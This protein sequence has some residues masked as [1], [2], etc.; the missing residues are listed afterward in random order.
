MSSRIQFHEPVDRWSDFYDQAAQIP[1]G[2]VNSSGWKNFPCVLPTHPK[3]DRGRHGGINVFSGSYR[4]WNEDCQRTAARRL[5][6]DPNSLILTP[7]EFLILTRDLSALDAHAAVEAYRQSRLDDGPQFD[8]FDEA[9]SRSFIPQSSEVLELV[10]GAQG[11][12]H[13]NLDIVREYLSARLLDYA[14]L[15]AAG[16]GY[17]PESPGQEECLIFPYTVDGRIVGIRGRTLDSRKGGIRNSWACLYNLDTI[18]PTDRIGII[19]EGETDTLFLQQELRKAGLHFPVLGTPGVHF[20]REWQRHLQQFQRVLAIPQA[21]DAAQT[22]LQD[23]QRSLPETIEFVHLPWRPKQ[24]GKDIVDFAHQNPIDNLISRLGLERKIPK[25]VQSLADLYAK[26][27]GEVPWVVENLIERGTKTLIV[28]EPKTY[29]TWLGL[30][31]LSSI[32][33]G[34]PFLGY[35][36]WRVPET[37][38]TGLLVEEEGSEHRLG[39]RL[40]LVFQHTTPPGIWILHRQGVLLDEPAA[41]AL[42]EEDVLQL[43][44]DILVLDPYSSLHH[45]DENT[46]QGTR[47]VLAGIDRLVH[48]RPS[49]AIVIIHHT[50]K[51]GSTARGSGALF[52]S[53]DTQIVVQ[54][55][56]S[57]SLALS[58]VGRDLSENSDL[59]EFIFEGSLG[60]HRPTRVILPEATRRRLQ[61]D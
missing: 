33:S 53:V 40:D 44:P 22:F 35:P 49:M 30:Q 41:L 26:A 39:K 14:T 20:P 1:K 46:V 21:D 60:R 4:C 58:I 45:Q 27:E 6:K 25:R 16:V 37:N 42:L 34:E 15:V 29:K 47:V 48:L 7:R 36:P 52:G 17:V 18:Q 19:V 28:G 51:G 5:G 23:L 24:W 10:A 3:K 13:P 56:E 11:R 55:S 61:K 43:K 9:F 59:P 50:A 38:L 31:L 54:R 12:L 57:G 32:T 2:D 8:H